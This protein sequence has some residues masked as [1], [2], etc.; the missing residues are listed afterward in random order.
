[1][2]F[3][4]R[5]RDDDTD[6]RLVFRDS[7]TANLMANARRKNRNRL[8][9]LYFDYRALQLGGSV[10][11][12][13]QSPTGGGVLGRF[14]GIQAGY[15]F[16]PKWKANVV[17]GVPTE[18]LLDSKRHFYGASVDAEALTSHLSGSLYGIQ[19][20]IDGEVDRRAIGSELRYFSG[21]VSLSS[22]LDYDTSIKGL[23]IGSL[24]GTWQSEGN[25]T[26]NFLYDRRTTPMLMLGNALFFQNPAAATQ[27]TRLKDL[28]GVNT[29]EALRQQVKATT[30]YTTQGL[31]GA[32]TPITSNWQTGANV[33]LTNVGAIEPVPIILPNGSPSTGNLWATG[34]QLIGTNL[35]SVR[36][37]HVLGVNYLKGPL[38]HGELLTYNNSTQIAEFWLVEP[39]L[40]YY[41][42][43][44]NLG[45][46]TSRWSPGLRL[47]YRA[48]Q[49]IS[50][51][52][53]VS[54]EFSTTTGPSRNETANRVFYSLG[55][56]Y[57]F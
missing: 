47:T 43:S 28:L 51:E 49:Q 27:A 57:D 54:G 1:V 38:Y 20:V 9:A 18:T 48:N 15:Y 21:G 37:T 40:K 6:M 7:F 42:Q 33:S 17:A 3:N 31:I 53:E 29:V 25:S 8:S 56:R 16:M 36:D 2:D 19:Q 13:R 39:S 30:S 23:N 45:V 5:Y 22:L 50:I 4:W 14:D 55:A 52:T 34:A 32:T 11:L 24:Q 26:V 44:D 10:R 35:Y 12:G 46:K 41:T